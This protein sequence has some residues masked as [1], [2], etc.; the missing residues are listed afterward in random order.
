MNEKGPSNRGD[1]VNEELPHRPDTVCDD[2]CCVDAEMSLLSVFLL[3]SIPPS[4]LL[5]YL[6]MSQK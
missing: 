4:V 3:S 1:G 2:R 5:L 6:V